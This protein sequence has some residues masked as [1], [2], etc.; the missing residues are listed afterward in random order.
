MH[1]VLAVSNLSKRYNHGLVVENASFFLH[2]EEA[3][4]LLGANGAGK[5][6]MIKCVLGLV[7]ASQGSVTHPGLSP[8]YLPELPQLP[9]SLSALA[10]LQF[11]CSALGLDS[12][13]AEKILMA[14][15]LSTDAH[16]QP[17]RQYSKGMRQRT[18][19]ALTLCGN[20]KLVC[21][22]EPMSGL[23]ALGRAEV[24]G[25]LKEKKEE[26]AAF[27]MSSHIV[28]DMVQLCDRVLIMAHGRICEDAPIQDHS[29][30][31]AKMLEDKL[32]QWTA[33]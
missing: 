5:S 30:A 13:L 4:G 10:L 28:S 12:S 27:L 9:A 26:G 3:V 24:L 33:K 11:K 29:L 2:P 6:T 7:H 8:A 16:K 20:P 21:L 25:L 23:D 18:A 19:L 14:V 15:N 1:A 32:A 22:D 17:I 31:E